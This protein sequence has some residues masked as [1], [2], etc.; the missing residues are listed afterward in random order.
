MK[1][2]KRNIK[3]AKLQIDVDDAQT[4][5]ERKLKFI[6]FEKMRIYLNQNE[7]EYQRDLKK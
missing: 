5:I 1:I 2:V 6:K 7:N 3:I 4:H